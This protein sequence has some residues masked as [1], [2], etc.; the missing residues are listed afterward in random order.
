LAFCVSCGNQLANDERFCSKC[1]ADQLPKAGDA[2]PATPQYPPAPLIPVA[3][4]PPAAAKQGQNKVMAAVIGA[5][6]L[7]AL[8]HFLGPQQKPHK[9]QQQQS[10]QIY[11]V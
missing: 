4:M 10:G 5:A 11:L 7:V 2:P 6:V 9:Q 1:G 8:Y 3:T